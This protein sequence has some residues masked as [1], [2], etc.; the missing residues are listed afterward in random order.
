[1]HPE[2]TSATED[3]LS[4]ITIQ[5]ILT[6]KLYNDLGFSLRERLFIL[7]EAQSTW[8]LNI[9]L[10]ALL[11]LAQTYHEYFERTNQNLYQSKKV[12]VPRPEI[13]VI[14]TGKKKNIPKTISLSK[15]FFEGT[16]V[17]LDIKINV[18]CEGGENNIINQYIIF[19]KV[20]DEQRALHGRSKDAITETIRICKSRDIL[21]EYL[22]SHE[23]EVVSIMMSLCDEE[24]VIRTYVKSERMDAEQESFKEAA[25][26]MIRSGKISIDDVSKYFPK[27]SAQSIQALKADVMQPS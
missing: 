23:K 21:C 4:D 22:S 10:R 27:L 25:L 24:E 11:Y 5:N 8:T 7:V 19:S 12:T 26:I 15:D 13:N 17:S 18:L 14:Y 2:D 16:E 3:D 6:D 9:I 20:Y 1:M